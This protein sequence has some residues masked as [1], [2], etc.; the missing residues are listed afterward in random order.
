LFSTVVEFNDIDDEM[1]AEDDS[2]Q[3]TVHVQ[4]IPEPAVT[5]PVVHVPHRNNTHLQ[6]P[7]TCGTATKHLPKL[8]QTETNNNNHCPAH[9]GNVQSFKHLYLHIAI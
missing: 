9:L 3:Y 4:A 7:K 6:L 2:Q 8:V 1:K 5:L